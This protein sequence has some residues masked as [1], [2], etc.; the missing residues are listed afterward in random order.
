MTTD[1]FRLAN[2]SSQRRNKWSKTREKGHFIINSYTEKGSAGE[3]VGIIGL[4]SILHWWKCKE[5]TFVALHTKTILRVFFHATNLIAQTLGTVLHVVVSRL[6]SRHKPI[7]LGAG[8][9]ALL[10]LGSALGG[11]GL[12][13][14]LTLTCLNHVLNCCFTNAFVVGHLVFAPCLRSCHSEHVTAS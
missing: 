5:E 4:V 2:N 1:N 7:G 13:T 12:I 14:F 8:F 3:E 6:L 9:K 11:F 10:Y